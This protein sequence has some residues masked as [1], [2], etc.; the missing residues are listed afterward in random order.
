MLLVFSATVLNPGILAQ[1][2]SHVTWGGDAYNLTALGSV[3]MFAGWLATS[4]SLRPTSPLK[5]ELR[6]HRLK[7]SMRARTATGVP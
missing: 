6:C 5:S 4:P 1:P 2:H 7:L 3:W